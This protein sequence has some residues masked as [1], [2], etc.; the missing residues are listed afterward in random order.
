MFENW[1]DNEYGIESI[2]DL[3][4][5]EFCELYQEFRKEIK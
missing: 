1:L 2:L 3:T 5:D 4:N